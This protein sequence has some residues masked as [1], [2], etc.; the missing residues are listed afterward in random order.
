MPITI[1]YIAVLL[2]NT[3]FYMQYAALGKT[4]VK[5]WNAFVY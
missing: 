4:F 3:T 1:R 2:Y 5:M